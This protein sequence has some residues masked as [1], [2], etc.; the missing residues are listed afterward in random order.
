MLSFPNHNQIQKACL[1][2]WKALGISVG[3]SFNQEETSVFLKYLLLEGLEYGEVRAW[4][5]RKQAD[6]SVALRRRLEALLTEARHAIRI[7]GGLKVLTGIPWDA[8][9]RILSVSLYYRQRLIDVAME[10]VLS[11]PLAPELCI[12]FDSTIQHDLSAI[13]PG[14]WNHALLFASPVFFTNEFYPLAVDAYVHDS[15]NYGKQQTNVLGVH[16]DWLTTDGKLKRILYL[17]FDKG[18]FVE[19]DVELPIVPDSVNFLCLGRQEQEKHQAISER[20][21]CLQVN[22]S[23]VSM[24]ADD[25]AATLAK[26][27][28]LGLEV[29][30][31]Q[32]ISPGNLAKAF[33]FLD[34][35]E[36]IAVKP[37]GATEGELV[38]FF[39][40]SHPQARIALQHHLERCW[41]QG[42]AIVQQRRDGVFFRAPVSGECHSLALRF[43]LT[44]NRVVGHRLE[45]GYAQLGQDEQSPASCGQGGR[46]IPVDIALSSLSGGSAFGNQPFRLDP[47]DWNNIRAQTERAASLFVGLMLIGLDVLLDH[48]LHGKIRPIFLEANPRPAGLSHSRLLVDDPMQPAINGVSL[49][50]WGCLDS[51]RQGIGL[52]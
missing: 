46:I 51:S 34:S 18:R 42:K 32:E 31:Y 43:N 27:S 29:P 26:W 3:S 49:D 30:A 24:L 39:R 25:K 41:E 17:D 33:H 36:E 8:V 4:R 13:L 9:N 15:E 37:N 16:T 21:N 6:K 40:R 44:T 47:N 7:V 52:V 20:I 50:L 1:Q 28:A 19:T 10:A 38:A 5:V 14:A 48:D 22:P 23:K 45:S 12:K 2:T 11:E 35:F